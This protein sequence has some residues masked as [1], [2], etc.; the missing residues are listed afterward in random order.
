MTAPKPSAEDVAMAQRWVMHPHSE[1]VQLAAEIAA[2]REAGRKE[3]LEE[4]ARECADQ[5][6]A[7]PRGTDGWW[8]SNGCF[9]RIRAI[10]EPSPPAAAKTS[11][12][13]ATPP[14][15]GD[16]VKKVKAKDRKR[17]PCAACGKPIGTATIVAGGDFPT[18]RLCLACGTLRDLDEVFA[19]I[20]ERTTETSPSG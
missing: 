18:A 2:V 13:T 14:A 6:A 15:A 3:G 7:Y 5:G 19:M 11:E 20:L 16:E 17:R 8:A 4:A 12:V 9:N 1:T 10:I